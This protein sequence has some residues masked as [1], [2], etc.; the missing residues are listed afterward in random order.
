MM[1]DEKIIILYGE[2]EGRDVIKKEIKKLPDKN[3]QRRAIAMIETF[4]S[5]DIRNTKNV[6]SIKDTYE[7]KYFKIRVILCHVSSNIYVV[8]HVF[9]KRSD[10]YPKEEKELMVDRTQEVLS[11]KDEIE[12]YA[13]SNRKGK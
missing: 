3:F 5:G 2:Y 11:K 6:I 10:S 8:T 7:L 1:Q 12:S 4:I 13:I 9:T